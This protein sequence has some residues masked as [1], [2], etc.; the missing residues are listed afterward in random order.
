[1]LLARTAVRRAFLR[2]PA[3]AWKPHTILARPFATGNGKHDKSTA[4]KPN[5]S[6]Q[7]KARPTPTE[8]GKTGAKSILDEIRALKS[9]G[10]KLVA[11]EGKYSLDD[12]P[13][14]V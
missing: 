7:G 9:Q 11:D 1:M 8:K 10:T 4:G 12:G 14:V 2:P 6:A 3:Q 5:Q 13:R